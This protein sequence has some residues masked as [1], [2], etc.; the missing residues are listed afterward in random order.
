[1]EEDQEEDGEEN[2]GEIIKYIEKKNLKKNTADI[3]NYSKFARMI[4]LDEKNITGDKYITD[5]KTYFKCIQ[6]HF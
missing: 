4:A 6:Y 2:I 5:D 1:M 3:N